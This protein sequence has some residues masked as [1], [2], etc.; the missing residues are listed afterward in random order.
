MK[1]LLAVAGRRFLHTAA[2]AFLVF[3]LGILSAPNL[4]DNVYLLG[5]TFLVALIAAALDFIQEVVP[6]FS[7]SLLLP[8]PWAAWADAFTQAFVASFIVTITGWLSAPDI[9]TWRSVVTAALIGALTAGVRAIEGL[10]TKGES[11][12]TKAGVAPASG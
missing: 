2:A 11:P 10:T 3:V 4:K 8:Q 12:I 6:K 1:Q 7:W 9:S 5:V